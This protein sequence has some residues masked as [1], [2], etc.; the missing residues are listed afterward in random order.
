VLAA[1][2]PAISSA[3]DA[4]DSF[5]SASSVSDLAFSDPQVDADQ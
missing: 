3:D 5:I 1:T 4:I 2:N